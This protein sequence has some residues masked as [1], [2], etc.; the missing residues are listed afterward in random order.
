MSIKQD[1]M[2]DRIRQILSELLLREVSDPRLGGVTVTEV[3][4]DHE[5]MF[6]DVYV[7]ALADESRKPEVLAGLS[8]ATGFLRREVGKRVRLRNTPE[9]HFHWDAT[10]ERGE[11]MNQLL[12]TL[13]IPPPDPNDIVDEDDFD[14]DED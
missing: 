3:K 2:A 12:G 11:R 13:H 8:R 5:L 9:L 1:R 7:N 10:L 6:A 14:D 4:I